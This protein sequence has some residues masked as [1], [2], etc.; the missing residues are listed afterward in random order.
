[1]KKDRVPQRLRAEELEKVVGGVG[2]NSSSQGF[3]A[4]FGASKALNSNGSNS[5]RAIGA[6]KF[7]L[8]T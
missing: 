6:G 2:S 1:M 8:N 7:L 5:S 3:K 4:G